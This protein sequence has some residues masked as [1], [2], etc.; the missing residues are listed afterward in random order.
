MP[1]LLGR[2]SDF[3]KLRSFVDR[4]IEAVSEPPFNFPPISA[5]NGFEV[6]NCRQESLSFRLSQSRPAQFV[7]CDDN[8]TSRNSVDR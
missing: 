7:S 6:I 4:K 5:K 3:A 8:S 2:K 1:Y